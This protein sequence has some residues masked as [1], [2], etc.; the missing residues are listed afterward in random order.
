MDDNIITRIPINGCRNAILIRCLQGVNDA[1]QFGGVAACGGGIGEDEA[2][3]FLGVNNED[4]ADGEGDT[5]GVNVG[6][7]L[8]VEP[9]AMLALVFIYVRA[10]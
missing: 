9:A 4:G 7:V 5:A 2:D 8:V 3:G 1:K 6:G 10:K